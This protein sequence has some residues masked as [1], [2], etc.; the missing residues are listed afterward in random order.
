MKLPQTL[1]VVALVAGLFAGAAQAIT[2]NFPLDG[3][4]A[5]TASPGTGTG[6]VTLIDLSPA[7]DDWQI[8]WSISYQNL[9]GTVT[10]AHFH[11][12]AT[13]GVDAGV[14]LPTP[15][16]SNP[17]VGNAIISDAFAAEIQAGLWYHNIHTSFDPSGE[18]RGQ[19]VPE[20]ASLALLGM[21]SLLIARRRRMA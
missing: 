13:Y 9:I 19:V 11:G 3:P 8:T 5:G 15:F 1:A 20:P 18:I 21:G 2:Y 16:D 10:N 12:P 17:M 14:R 7:A 4:Q 6:V